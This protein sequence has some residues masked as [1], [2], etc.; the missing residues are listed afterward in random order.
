MGRRFALGSLIVV[1]LTV[2]GVIG[3]A[4]SI[5]H[6]EFGGFRPK[7]VEPGIGDV[8]EP[9]APGAPQTI[10]VLGTDERYGDRK[11]G[12]PVRSDTM[13]VVHLDA[14]REA[15]AVMS[16]P[17]DLLVTIPG[18]GRGPINKAYSI[19]G[20]KLA[21]DTVNEL[22]LG[23]NH[24][25]GV[26]FGGFRRAVNRL[27]CVYV[28]VDRRYFNDN[29]PP[30]A[31]TENYATID[32][33]P[34]YQRVCGGK[35]LDYV[36]FRHLDDDFVRASRQQD[37][38]RQAKGQIGVTKAIGDRKALLKIFSDYSESDLAGASDAEI[39]GLLKLAYAASK[40]PVR[41]VPFPPTER[42][43]DESLVV[44]PASLR[45]A[46]RRFEN[47]GAK[48]P[49]S[50]RRPRAR[51]APSARD[52]TG[53][54]V[55]RAGGERHA[56]VLAAKL[57]R[58][59]PVFYPRTRLSRAG[60]ADDSPR[61]YRIEHSGGGSHAAYRIV[62]AHGDDG[63]YYG[64]QGTT[65]RSPPILKTTSTKLRMRG[66]TYRIFREGGHIRHVAWRTRRGRVLGLQHAVGTPVGRADAGHRAVADAG[67]P[68]TWR[69]PWATNANPSVSS[70]PA[71]S[72]W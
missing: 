15:T 43:P 28:D 16:L 39:F 34:G 11:A 22:G 71:T 32:L 29:D 3:V 65:W 9:V 63:Q 68:V 10:L 51:R 18:H 72:A 35:A 70:A 44:S 1:S 69:A 4:L 26:D 6:E 21:V 59:L 67:R 61:R 46:V 47:V 14:D 42:R 33:Q 24:V 48:R 60:Y 53:V 66:R 64:V 13:M 38:L 20:S 12:K 40:H 37:F 62:L 31:S 7:P 23:V 2:A 27:G 45:S 52:A 49:S 41:E 50:Q 36:R 54:V 58:T 5:M 19:G 17:R 25:I 30:V 57:D 56:L 8:L 55:D